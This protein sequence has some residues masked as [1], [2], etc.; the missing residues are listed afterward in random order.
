MSSQ[1]AKQ[2]PPSE[3]GLIFWARVAAR[4]ADSLE[5][6]LYLAEVFRADAKTLDNYTTDP[7]FSEVRKAWAERYVDLGGDLK[8]TDLKDPTAFLDTL[9]GKNANGIELR[10]IFPVGHRSVP[11]T[12]PLAK[13]PPKKRRGG[14][15]GKYNNTLMGDE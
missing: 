14:N 6:L 13:Q 8:S 15:G 4:T 1:P 7:A 12:K 9:L 11:E 5:R 2:E 3:S 10:K